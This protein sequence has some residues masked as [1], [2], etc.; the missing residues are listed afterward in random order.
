MDKHVWT[1]ST[2]NIDPMMKESVE[3]IR[4]ITCLNGFVAVHPHYPDG[5]LW[6]FDSKANAK[7]ARKRMQTQ[8]IVVGRN[9]GRGRIE[10]D[11]LV[12]L[13]GDNADD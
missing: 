5:T 2:G 4:F 13:G 7:R 6:L 9:I 11:T 10:G 8:G 1:V 12:L 3:A